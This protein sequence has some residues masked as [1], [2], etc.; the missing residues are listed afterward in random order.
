MAAG[1]AAAVADGVADAIVDDVTEVVEGVAVDDSIF[2]FVE[3]EIN[4]GDSGKKS[5]TNGAMLEGRRIL[6]VNM[7]ALWCNWR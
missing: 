5:I 7:L 3:L 6:K 4:N 1:A 2:A